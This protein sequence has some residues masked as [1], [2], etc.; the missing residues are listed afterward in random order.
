LFDLHSGQT[1]FESTGSVLIDF[2]SGERTTESRQ[3]SSQRAVAGSELEDAAVG[4]GD[5]VGD[6][7]NGGL[8]VQ[9]VLAEFVSAVMK[10]TRHEGALQR[11][12]MEHLEKASRP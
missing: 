2:D 4:C 8:V 12:L 7:G 6:A 9:E 3:R 1:A 10:G 5:E 11:V